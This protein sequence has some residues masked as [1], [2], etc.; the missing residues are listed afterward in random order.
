MLNI[1]LNS[2]ESFVHVKDENTKGNDVKVIGYQIGIPFVYVVLINNELILE[3]E[4]DYKDTYN[5]FDLIREALYPDSYELVINTINS[6]KEDLMEYK[7]LLHWEEYDLCNV[8]TFLILKDEMDD[9][10]WRLIREAERVLE[11]NSGMK[12]FF[13]SRGYS[14]LSANWNKP[15]V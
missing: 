5:P 7:V 3:K 14:E 15:F 9:Y 6:L 13:D 8:N 1:P 4:C 11:D 10:Y 12:W 2:I